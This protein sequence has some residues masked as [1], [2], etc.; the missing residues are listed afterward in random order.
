MRVAGAVGATTAPA[1][2]DLAVGW[3][4]A[5]GLRT[6]AAIA[7]WDYDTEELHEA[8]L[9]SH[10]EVSLI[11]PM[12]CAVRSDNHA[13]CW[14]LPG[15][16]LTGPPPTDFSELAAGERRAGPRPVQRLIAVLCPFLG[17]KAG[18]SPEQSADY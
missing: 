1:S 8:P 6:D 11:G 14:S 16:V 10:R 5:C 17:S 7:C 15:M 9:G 18:P 3:R 12:L 13:L 2:S 4:Y